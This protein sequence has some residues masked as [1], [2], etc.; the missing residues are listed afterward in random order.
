M[1]R[2]CRHN[3]LA[4]SWNYQ[5][6]GMTILLLFAATAVLSVI[7]S[8]LKRQVFAK[9]L[10]YGCQTRVTY[11]VFVTAFVAFGLVRSVLHLV[12]LSA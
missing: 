5:A 3:V 8:V 6:F 2:R 11:I 10:R 7:P 1:V 9:V 4:Y 12:N